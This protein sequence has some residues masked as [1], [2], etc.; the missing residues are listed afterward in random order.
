MKIASVARPWGL[1]RGSLTTPSMSDP[2]A[3]E[4]P[5][6][7][8]LRPLRAL[9][10]LLRP[11]RTRLRLALAALVIASATMLWLPMVGRNLID[12][13]LV[14]RN[15]QLI[16]RYTGVFILAVILFATFAAFRFY[17]VTWLGERVVA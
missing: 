14:A 6:A 11:Y 12:F 3:A 5:K 8:S 13:G 10:P 17:L 4:R 16:D 2:A 15:P 1:I 7:K 9:W